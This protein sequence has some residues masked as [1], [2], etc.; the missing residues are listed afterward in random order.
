MMNGNQF[1]DAT[2]Q[3]ETN[4]IHLSDKS[5]EAVPFD[6]ERFR[7]PQRFVVDQLIDEREKF[8]QAMENSARTLSLHLARYTLAKAFF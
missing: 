6:V 1:V 3:F 2:E 7:E 5:S 4:Q 8:L